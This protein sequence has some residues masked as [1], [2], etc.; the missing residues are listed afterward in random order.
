MSKVLTR[1]RNRRSFPPPALLCMNFLTRLI[2]YSVLLLFVFLAAAFG[3][4][5][6][7]RQQ[8][9]RLR[10][11]AIE[12]K[13]VQFAA[14]VRAVTPVHPHW[15]DADEARLGAMCGGHVAIYGDYIP[16]PPED[17]AIL[18]FDQKL[19]ESPLEPV[20]ARVSFVASPISRLLTT[21]QRV[22]VGLL[23]FGFVLLA[24][25]VFAAT[26]SWNASG[27][28]PGSSASAGSS[29]ADIGSLTHLAE[30]SV[31]QTAA[32]TREREVRQLAEED[33]VLKQQ[34]LNQSLEGKV[35]LGHDLHDGIIQSL[36]AAG[37]TIESARA[38][39]PENP[40]EADRRLAQ[41][42]QNL[43]ATIRDV[44]TYITG[45]APEHLRQAGFAQA[46]AAL[47][48]ELGG[49]RAVNFDLKIDGEATAM[50]TAEQSTETLQVAREAIS[51]SLRHGGASFVNVR[52]LKSGREVC[53]LVQDNGTGFDPG[54]PGSTGRG[55]GNMQ[56]RA[57]RIGA[58]VRVE[59]QPGAGTRMI[60]TL[61]L[62]P[63]A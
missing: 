22:T 56:A 32:L 62:L 30:T 27:T 21:Y 50:L 15:S 37:L 8:T 12:A 40:A 28:E 19:V 49:G 60:L 41:C 48:S 25:G 18:Y 14:I 39:Q 38:L 42:V 58:T 26:L 35:R 13:R 4:Q 55:L 63:T 45:L 9:H 23:F 57:G 51:N 31:A 34:M 36:Y 3:A 44:R 17:A 46:V 24:L 5:G 33:A 16:G 61:P 54:R 2:G 7:L 20:T 6:W 1:A 43:N 53:L 52:L 11:E 29:R 47:A 59:S 10:A